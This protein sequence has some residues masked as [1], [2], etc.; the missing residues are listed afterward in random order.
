M[1]LGCEINKFRFSFQGKQIA[2]AENDVDYVGDRVNLP[3]PPSNSEEVAKTIYPT[4]TPHCT[5]ALQAQTEDHRDL[6]L[7]NICP[8]RYPSRHF[9]AFGPS[10]PGISELHAE[11][12]N[13]NQHVG[14]RE[15]CT[16]NAH[17]IPTS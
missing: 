7:G 15:R 12:C 11:R 13:M 14:E 3:A 2:P 9:A 6:F 4:S 10:S 8:E 5:S 17:V 1:E 16:N